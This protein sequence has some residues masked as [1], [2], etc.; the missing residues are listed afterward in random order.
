MTFQA[1]SEALYTYNVAL[2]TSVGHCMKAMKYVNLRL[3][4]F[5]SC[6]A[7][8]TCNKVL[9]ATAEAFR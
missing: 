1:H 5:A 7:V 2:Q 9:L 6:E 4:M 8:Q 3:L